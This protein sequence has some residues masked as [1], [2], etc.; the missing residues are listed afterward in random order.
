MIHIK[1]IQKYDCDVLIVGGGPA[2][3]GLAYHLSKKGYKVIVAEAAI[4]PRD[5]VCGDGVSPIALAELHAMGITG[6]EKFA[7]ANEINKVGLFIKTD[8]VFIN[9]SKPD[10]LPYH[11]R[12]IPRIELDSWIYEA[13]KNAGAIY[14]ESTFS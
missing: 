10:H 1:Q 14:H 5:K 9:L 2:G 8:K 11:A 12:I 4:F 7:L 3:S 13:A 6:T